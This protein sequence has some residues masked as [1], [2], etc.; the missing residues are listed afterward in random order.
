MSHNG[1]SDAKPGKQELWRPI[2]LIVV[3]VAGG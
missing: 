1:N 3:I 2:V